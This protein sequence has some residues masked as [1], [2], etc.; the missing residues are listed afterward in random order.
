[1]AVRQNNSCAICGTT[2]PTKKGWHVDH[3][4][5]SGQVR[6]LLC[7]HCNQMLSNARDDV[8]VLLRGIYYLDRHDKFTGE[9][10][11]GYKV[12]D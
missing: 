4:H 6:D 9:N 1:M 7:H 12:Q 8:S 5:S 10:R 2:T 3:C 11:H